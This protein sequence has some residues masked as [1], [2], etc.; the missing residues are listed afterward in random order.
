MEKMN[1]G[2]EAQSRSDGF[3]IRLWLRLS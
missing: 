1:G 2:L 3:T